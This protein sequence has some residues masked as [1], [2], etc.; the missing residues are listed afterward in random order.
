VTVNAGDKDYEYKCR[1]GSKALLPPFGFI[2]ESP[3]YIAFHALSYN[4]VKYDK[5]ALFTIRSLDGSPVDQSTKIRVFHG[6][7]GQQIKIWNKVWTVAKEEI[8][9]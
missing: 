8:I 9:E 2:V 4:G 1:D 7:G 5:S 6:F 3:Q